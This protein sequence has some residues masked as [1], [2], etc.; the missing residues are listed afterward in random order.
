MKAA[1]KNEQVEQAEKTVRFGYYPGKLDFRAGGIVVSTLPEFSEAVNFVEKS[2]EGCVHNG[3]FYPPRQ[4]RNTRCITPEGLTCK[5]ETLPFCTRIFP[6][7]K[8]HSLTHKKCD[9]NGHLD[10]LVWCLGFFLGMRLTTTEAG[11]VDA[12]PISAPYAGSGTLVDFF[13]PEKDRGVAIMFADK[14]WRDHSPKYPRVPKAL[15]GVIHNLFLSQKGAYGVIPYEQFICLYTALEGCSFVYELT[16]GNDPKKIRHGERI[17]RLCQ[18]F[19]TPTPEWAEKEAVD[20]RNRA[21]HDGLFFG[22]PFGFGPSNKSDKK[23]ISKILFS[24]QNLVCRI[25]FGLLTRKVLAENYVRSDCNDRQ[26]H[27]VQLPSCGQ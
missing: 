12:T 2:N 10:F 7:P 20:I 24:M 8:T 18:A 3:W 19:D 26:L 14:F 9:G 11:F 5:V 4:R 25:L 21:I 6:L 15:A 17:A 23:K 16:H 27:R 1:Q 22:E 13:I